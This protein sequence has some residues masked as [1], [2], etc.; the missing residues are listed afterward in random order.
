[1]IDGS[2]LNI[3]RIKSYTKCCKSI[4]DNQGL[5]EREPN[6]YWLK[7]GCICP[8][9]VQQCCERSIRDARQYCILRLYAP[10]RLW[11]YYTNVKFIFSDKKSLLC[12][13]ETSIR[14]FSFV[15]LLLVWFCYK[16]LQPNFG[17]SLQILKVEIGGDIQS[18]GRYC[19][20]ILL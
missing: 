14:A 12:Y 3:L 10:V 17:A 20:Q 18:T 16:F 4:G 2:I 6:K 7:F 1:M 15:F 5:Q 11:I 8:K 9:T 19:S 13:L